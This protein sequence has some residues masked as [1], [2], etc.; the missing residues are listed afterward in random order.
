VPGDTAAVL[1][2]TCGELLATACGV[3]LGSGPKR[4]TAVITTSGLYVD[5]LIRTEMSVSDDCP[6]V[7]I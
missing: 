1:T 6:F 3:K 5:I 4:I 2:G 7:E